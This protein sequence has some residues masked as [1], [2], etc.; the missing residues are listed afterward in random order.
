M[1]R[2]GS[3]GKKKTILSENNLSTVISQ[4]HIRTVYNTRKAV[5]TVN[6]IFNKGMPYSD[7][8]RNIILYQGGLEPKGKVRYT[9]NQQ[10]VAGA[11][12]C[13]LRRVA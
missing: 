7:V 12:L 6:S 3:M 11:S 8:L 10:N 13:D 1:P 4:N 5:V 9:M 2:K